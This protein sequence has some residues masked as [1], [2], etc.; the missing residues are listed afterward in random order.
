MLMKP[1][2]LWVDMSLLVF[3]SQQ[4]TGSVGTPPTILFLLLFI[5]WLSP[6]DGFGTPHS[7]TSRESRSALISEDDAYHRLAP[8]SSNSPQPDTA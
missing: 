7:N 6:A 8:V 5:T 1:D 4:L 3:L 2:S